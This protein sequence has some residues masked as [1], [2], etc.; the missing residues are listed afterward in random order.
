MSGVVVFGRCPVP[1]AVKTRL[2]SGI[3]AQAAAEVYAALLDHTLGTA[4]ATGHDVVLSLA[5]ERRS[6]WTP[7]PGLRVEVQGE[8]DLGSRLAET[9]DRRFVEGWSRVLVIGSDCAAITTDRLRGALDVLRRHPVVLGPATDGGY[10]AVGQRRP[11]VEMF[12]S[13]PWS[14]PRTLDRTRALLR[15]LGVDWKELEELSDLDTVTDLR[16]QL[17]GVEMP[18]QLVARLQRAAARGGVIHP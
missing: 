1:G 16:R 7:P 13:V 6:S 9:F 3:G 2:A 10:W 12:S 17:T 8:G 4:L 11:G 15:A 18:S 14:S 5:D